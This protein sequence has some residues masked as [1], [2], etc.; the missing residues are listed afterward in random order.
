[1][2]PAEGRL[3]LLLLLLLLLML[4]LILRLQL[5][6]CVH[7]PRLFPSCRSLL[8]GDRGR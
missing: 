8:L 3:R 1:M 4:L 6:I 7:P 2:I 5:V